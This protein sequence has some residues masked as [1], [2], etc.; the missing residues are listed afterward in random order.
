MSLSVGRT[1]VDIAPQKTAERPVRPIGN[2]PSAALGDRVVATA[3]DPS[4]IRHFDHV[5][6]PQN[7]SD[8][9]A[10]DHPRSAVR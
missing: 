1:S 6:S 9:P 7:V 5:P 4:G 8:G 2:G 10:A 3:S